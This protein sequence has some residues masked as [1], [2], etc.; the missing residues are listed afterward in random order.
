MT[1]TLNPKGDLRFDEADKS[2]NLRC[3]GCGH[4]GEIDDD[5]LHGRVS[6]DH[7]D[8]RCGCTFHETR[9]WSAGADRMAG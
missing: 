4:W 9:D 1:L 2:W 8:C 3:P 7:T 5:Q 6:V